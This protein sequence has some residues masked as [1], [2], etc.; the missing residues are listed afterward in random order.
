M[1]AERCC[2]QAGQWG[3][4]PAHEA[5]DGLRSKRIGWAPSP[6]TVSDL[7]G[8]PVSPRWRRRC[9]R[10][11]RRR[12]SAGR[13]PKSKV[14]PGPVR[15]TTP[16]PTGTAAESVPA[17][18]TCA[19]A[20]GAPPESTR[21]AMRRGG[22][23]SWANHD[24]A[25]LVAGALTPEA[26]AAGPS[27]SGTRGAATSGAGRRGRRLSPAASSNAAT[28]ITTARRRRDTVSEPAARWSRMEQGAAS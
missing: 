9:R 16:G 10:R 6:T 22:A 14:P 27:G 25:L 13:R 15:A 28:A 23:P 4:R 2:M 21:P 20:S 5:R 8:L 3:P 1:P 12:R 19:P 24:M 11:V 26:G 18:T 7:A 17:I